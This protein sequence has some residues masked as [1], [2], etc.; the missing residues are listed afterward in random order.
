MLESKD[1]K[2][3]SDASGLKRSMEKFEFIVFIVIWERLLLA[4]NSASSALQA[5]ETDLS[6]ATWLLSMAFGEVT[7][8]RNSWESIITTAGAMSA[9]WK[10]PPQFYV[11]RKRRRM[12]FFDEL[13]N[14]ERL[15]DPEL[16]FKTHVFFPIIDTAMFQLQSRFEGQHLVSGIFSFLYPKSLLQLSDEDLESAAQKLQE[17][18][19]ADISSDLVS[20]LRSFRREFRQE[21]EGTKTVLDLLNIIISSRIM[22]SVPELA[23]ACVLFATLPVTVASA[24]RSFSKLKII[25]TYLRSSISQD[26]LD[27]LALLAIENESAK[28]L[29]TDDLIDKFAI[30]KARTTKL[31]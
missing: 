14:D 28:Q 27:G 31:H 18:Y 25:K 3:R 21:I 20:Q 9:V 8:M 10:I 22:S 16:A 19:S 23:T 15:Q 17:T 24:E 2:E 26:R 11:G 7:Y 4:I 6:C 1:A 5:V 30:N 29:N 13:S 12:K